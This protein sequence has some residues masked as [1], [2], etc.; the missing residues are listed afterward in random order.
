MQN[1][2]N[3]KFKY[4]IESILFASGD[5][6]DINTLTDVLEI[7][8]Q[9]IETML[10]EL[11]DEYN[12]NLRGFNIVKIN[13]TYQLTS[14]TI[15]FEHIKKVLKRNASSNLSKAAL[16]ALAIVAYKQPVSRM[17][18][19]Y[20][21]GVQSSSSMHLLL[22]RGLIETCGKLDIPGKPT[23]YKTSA[24]FLRLLDIEKI[25]DLKSFDT[26]SDLIQEKLENQIDHK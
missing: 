9:E 14:R 19:D 7:P 23:A 6:V 3:L 22:D 21:R 10:N 11:T 5:P 13:N 15:Y 16:E 20:I 1:Q 12:Y 4:I 25:E 2:E 24:E 17:E 18:I 8:K 26:F